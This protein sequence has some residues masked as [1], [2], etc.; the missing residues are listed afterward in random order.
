M[1]KRKPMELPGSFYALFDYLRS[2]GYTKNSVF[3]IL[4]QSHMDVLGELPQH[5]ASDFVCYCSYRFGCA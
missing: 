3:R 1:A 5:T 4:Y 2:R